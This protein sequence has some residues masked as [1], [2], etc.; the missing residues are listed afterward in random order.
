MPEKTGLTN[1]QLRTGARRALNLAAAALTTLLA[2]AP[3]PAA[4]HGEQIPQTEQSDHDAQNAHDAEPRRWLAG[5]H[6]IHSRYSVDWDE[7]RSPP[8]PILGGDAIYPTTTNAAMA[9]LHGLEWMVTTDHGGP[10]HSRVNRDFAYPELLA[11]RRAIPEVVQFYGMELDTPA[12]DHS[13]LIIAHSERERDELFLLESTFARRDAWPDD[14][15]RDTEA[16]ML[17]ALRTM[18]GLPEKPVVI[19]NHPSRSATDV[20]EFGRTTPRELRA[21][22]D[23]APQVAVGMAGAPGHQAA[24]VSR[25]GA[26]ANEPRQRP[27]GG[28]RTSPTLG[29]F[30]QMTA[31]VGGVWDSLLGEGRRWWIT[32]NSD[33]HI[34]ASEGGSDFWPGEYART[35]VHARKQHDDI[36]DGLRSGRVF[37][38]TGA[39]VTGLT[40]EVSA[41]ASDEVAHENGSGRRVDMLGDTLR[42]DGPG[43]VHVRAAL[44]DPSE[45]NAN[46]DLPQLERVDLIVGAVDAAD[47]DGNPSARVEARFDANSEGWRRDGE[48]VEIEH[49]F[50]VAGP[51][52]LRLRG[53]NTTE[54]EPQPDAPD[55]DP[56]TDLWFYSNPVFVTVE[57][58]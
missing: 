9:R 42:L 8:T 21:W 12:A 6:H 7:T 5:D 44:R 48:I 29:G 40:I 52:Y 18:D 31:R 38:A 58:T 47:G 57:G 17:A 26:E 41:R 49:T 3:A 45:A 19:A 30:D 33:S 20:G 10:G 51:V 43:T 37:V 55:E 2:A 1:T 13:T 27:R 11:S 16:Q 53:T 25:A 54:L 23:T 24:P 50:E 35:W 28:Y 22:N 36:L 34:H 56:W 15:T 39:L 32:A 14:P 46:G 4:A